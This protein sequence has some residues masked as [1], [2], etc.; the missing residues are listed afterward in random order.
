MHD[1]QQ[2][3]Y[4]RFKQIENVAEKNSPLGKLL[5]RA[6]NI[7]THQETVRSVLEPSCREHC[8]LANYRNGTLFLQTDSSA[9]GARLRMQQRA[10]VQQLKNTAVFAALHSVKVSVQPSYTTESTTRTAKK[11]SAQNAEQIMETAQ[12][13]DD[14][15]LKAALTRLAQNSRNKDNR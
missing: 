4:S 6:S 9:W 11:I 8:W 1:M 15:A 2:N 14:P 10:I 12:D 7:L 5:H 13:T 3:K